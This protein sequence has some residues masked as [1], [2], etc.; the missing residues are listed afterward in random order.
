MVIDA[1][2][3]FVGSATLCA[4]TVTDTGAGNICGAVKFPLASTRP[5][6]VGHEAPE[7][8]QRIAGSGCPALEITEVKACNAPSST[9]ATFGVNWM[10]ISLTTVT[11][12]VADFVGSAALVAVTRIVAGEGRSA[13]AVYM[14]LESITPSTEFPPATPLT[15]HDTEVLLV[16]VTVATNNWE[17]PSV[18]FSD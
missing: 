10:E 11:L 16:L 4:E 8:L 18:M 2:A 7:T 14:P 3:C 6:L 15:L 17:F 5:Q 13:G 9:P 12:T 1:D